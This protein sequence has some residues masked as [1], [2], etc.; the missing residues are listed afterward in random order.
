[1][2]LWYW[3][4][5]LV[6]TSARTHLQGVAP[7]GRAAW[8]VIVLV[9]GASYRCVET[10][11]QRGA[12]SRWRAWVAI[13]ATVA[14]L[15]LLPL[16]APLSEPSTAAV[17]AVPVARVEPGLR[18]TAHPVRI[19]LLGDSM[20]GTLGVGLS[21]IAPRYGAQV[22]NEGTPGCSLASAVS[23]KVLTYTDPP[24]AP[25]RSG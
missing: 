24:G 18:T 4:V 25:C 5:L 3:P 22:V 13:P 7:A 20:A 10:P 9:A 19:L 6:M 2:Y 12:L 1:M 17:A 23:V 21:Q 14:A 11:I 15:M 8:L 16:L